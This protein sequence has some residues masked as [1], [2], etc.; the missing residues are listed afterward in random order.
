M[1]SFLGFLALFVLTAAPVVA[2]RRWDR[3]GPGAR[4]WREADPAAPLRPARRSLQQVAADVR[5]LSRAT[6]LVPAGTPMARR[7]GLWAA[8][9]DVLA[10]A[11]ELLEV[12][13][14]LAGLPEG[15][16]RDV[17]RLRL[18]SALR[19]AGLVVGR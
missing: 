17:E 7:R 13:H 2:L 19:G 3:A 9:D 15:R 1:H 10:E 12:P 5:R 4:R 8:Y 14:A 16:A 18:L 6:E 11:A